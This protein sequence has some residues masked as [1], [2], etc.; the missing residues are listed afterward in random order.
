MKARLSFFVP[1]GRTDFRAWIP[2]QITIKSAHL[3]P[4]WTGDRLIEKF[5]GTLSSQTVNHT[6]VQE[7]NAAR[8]EDL[9]TL[10]R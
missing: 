8:M 6:F 9:E 4:I 5:K 10:L 3:V 1:A 2:F 7:S